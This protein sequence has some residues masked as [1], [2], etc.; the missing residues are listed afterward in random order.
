MLEKQQIKFTPVHVIRMV[1]VYAFLSKLR[2][3]QGLL[4]PIE[5]APRCTKLLGKSCLIHFVDQPELAEDSHGGKH[6]RLAHMGTWMV[7]S[8][9]DQILDPSL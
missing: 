7:M 3:V 5:V 1:T 8:I 9:Q 6:Q 2:E 4:F